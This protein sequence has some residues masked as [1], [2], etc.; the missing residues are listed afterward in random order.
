MHSFMFIRQVYRGVV[1]L[2]E[3][4]AKDKNDLALGF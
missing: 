2:R 3:A 1:K 4:G